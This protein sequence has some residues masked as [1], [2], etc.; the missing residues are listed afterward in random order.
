MANQ[1]TTQNIIS[2]TALPDWYKNYLEQVMGRAVGAADEPYQ[3]YG[4]P[5][6]AALTPEQLQVQGMVQDMQGHQTGTLNQALGLYGQAGDINSGAAGAGSFAGATD[7]FNQGAGANTAGISSPFVNQGVG[8]AGLS[9]QGSAM[10]AGQPYIAASTSPTGL[11]AAAP[12]LSQAS[13]TFPG[14]ASSYMSPYTTQVLDQIASR[15]ARNLS[16]N[17]LPSISDD[18][19]RAGGY[20]S[21]RQRDLVGRA[22]RDTQEA[23]LG[24]Q[25]RSLESGYAQAGQQFQA[26]QARTA[27]LAGTAGGLGTSQQ[28]ILQGA[29]TG[30][31]S[32]SSADLARMLSSGQTIGQLGLGQAGVA[33]TDAS[34]QIQAGQGLAG[35]GQSQIQAAQQ[36]NAQRLQAA[37]GIQGLSG[38]AQNMGFQQIAALDAVGQQNQGQNQ[39]NLDAGYQEYLRQQN[40]PWQT[41]GNMSNV[42]QGLPVNQSSNTTTTGSQPGP[43]TLSQLGG[44]GLGVAGL[45][46]SGLFKAKGGKVKKPK[47]AVSYGVAPRRGLS[48][49]Y[50]KAA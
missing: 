21:T 36:D 37:Q 27:G 34:R 24:E 47:S 39:A 26:D 16:E 1:T 14:A 9:A 32:L 49:A 35:I 19:V 44:I 8:L 48:F 12:Y 7:Y 10:G 45:A 43:S 3:P 22:A 13:Q 18:F 50:G 15:G 17:I 29:G 42:I 20:G 6:V 31:G 30:L 2:S 23:I 11:L 38:Q 46:G 25:A 33:G 41:I 5:T 4:G 28:Q 40:Y